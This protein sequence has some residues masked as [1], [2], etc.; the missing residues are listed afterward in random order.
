L[1]HTLKLGTQYFVTKSLNPSTDVQ[2]Q[3][4]HFLEQAKF[5]G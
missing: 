5:T 4:Y 3:E 2:S 1:L